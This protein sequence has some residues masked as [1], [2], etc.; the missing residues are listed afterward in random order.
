MSSTLLCSWLFPLFFCYDHCWHFRASIGDTAVLFV[1]F[2]FCFLT[3]PRVPLKKYAFHPEIIGSGSRRLYLSSH[4]A[5]LH[6]IWLWCRKVGLTPSSHCWKF[7][8]F[9]VQKQS[10][11]AYWLALLIGVQTQL[12]KHPWEV[13]GG[14]VWVAVQTESRSVIGQDR[15]PL[16]LC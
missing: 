10:A 9:D 13:L 7:W 12:H 16:T 14:Q 3:E 4:G 11:V 15:V 8:L 6:G 5:D 1:C 2:S